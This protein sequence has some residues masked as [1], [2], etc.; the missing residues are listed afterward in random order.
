MKFKNIISTPH[1]L[2]LTNQSLS[3]FLG[4]FTTLILTRTLGLELF[5]EWTLLMTIFSFYDMLRA[6]TIHSALMYFG[7]GTE[8]NKTIAS[9]WITGLLMSFSTFLLA[10]LFFLPE[11]FT[12]LDHSLLII[13][14]WFPVL[15]ISSLPFKIT[16]WI[17]QLK[18]N[19]KRV[20]FTRTT[21]LT[22][23]IALLAT[24]L[25]SKT[26][27]SIENVLIY[28][29]ISMLIPGTIATVLG[30]NRILDIKNFSL[31]FTKIFWD[32]G[33]FSVS[34]L[35]GTSLLKSTSI[36]IISYFLG[37][38]WVSLYAIPLKIIEAIE[39][40]IRAF[41]SIALPKFSFY[42]HTG[43]IHLIKDELKRYIGSV[44]IIIIPILVSFV[45]FAPFLLNIL[46]GTTVNSSVSI[47][48]ILTIY[49]LL[50]P[51][52]RFIGTTLDSLKKPQI[53]SVKIYLMVS[54]NTIGGVSIAFLGYALEYYAIITVLTTSI[55]IF[56]GSIK[57]KTLLNIKD[58]P[59]FVLSSFGESKRVFKALFI[60]RKTIQ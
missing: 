8:T 42:Y 39:I 17:S 2:S 9:C 21:Q 49:G 48:R 44:S 58:F 24:H 26:T 7:T 57:L 52:D 47:L 3:A 6:G 29:I 15:A 35:I 16:I 60:E 45:I 14:K 51:L 40:P 59:Y 34:N 43:N 23:F 37:P 32:Y 56:Y 18:L 4:L 12:W 50:V 11:E 1:C 38:T 33:K 25:S 53:N 31:S 36:F 13:V 41:V 5:G 10:L 20:L 30:Y 54:F 28:Y 55:G 46:G 22:I 19:F 27:P